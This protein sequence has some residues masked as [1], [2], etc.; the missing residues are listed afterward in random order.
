M[1]I[2]VLDIYWF[3]SSNN[4]PY[5]SLTLNNIIIIENKYL[6][7]QTP[8]T[9]VFHIIILTYLNNWRGWVMH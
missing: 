7:T 1:Y 3:I 6:I 5:L 9:N 2:C 4:M 8:T